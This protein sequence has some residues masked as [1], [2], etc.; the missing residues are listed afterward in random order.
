MTAF[1]TRLAT[2]FGIGE[3]PFAPG[4]FASAAALPLG[5]ALARMGWQGV[6]AGAIAATIGGIWACDRHARKVGVHD[7]SECV[8]DEVAGQWFALAPIAMVARSGDWWLYALAFLLFRLFDIT[9]PW[10][11]SA[12]ERL[13]G[14][15]GVMMDDVL[16]GFAAGLLL[17]AAMTLR[18]L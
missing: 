7:P 8:I 4:T 10:P 6:V 5:W 11:I 2:C 17:Y 1:S 12:G 9:K 3:I 18:F 15:L 14:G 16:A 13:P